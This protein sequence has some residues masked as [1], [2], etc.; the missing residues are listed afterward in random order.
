M[1]GWRGG[2]RRKGGVRKDDGAQA[3]LW[4]S[5]PVLL[6]HWWTGWNTTGATSRNDLMNELLQQKSPA[7]PHHPLHGSLSPCSDTPG[8]EQPLGLKRAY[9][10]ACTFTPATP[11]NP[12]PVF[13]TNLYCFATML[14]TGKV[15]EWCL[16]LS[17]L[18]SPTVQQQQQQLVLCRTKSLILDFLINI[19]IAL[20]CF[21]NQWWSFYCI[22]PLCPLKYVSTH[23]TWKKRNKSLE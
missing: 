22:C 13:M 21:P 14:L 2:G 6:L 1:G 12:T 15:T 8:N 16:L 9:L 11:A 10:M 23:T 3:L 4:E 19:S 18:I 7:V 20:S 17:D 5:S